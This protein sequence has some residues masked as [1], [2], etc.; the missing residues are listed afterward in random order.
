MPV[1]YTLLVNS[2]K[3]KWN[4]QNQDTLHFENVIYRLLH[5]RSNITISF[6]ELVKFQQELNFTYASMGNTGKLK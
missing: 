3:S 4:Y 2:D 1:I 6:V 5:E